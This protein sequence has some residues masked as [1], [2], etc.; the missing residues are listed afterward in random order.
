MDF[1]PLASL[2]AGQHGCFASRQL[3]DV[4]LTKHQLGRLHERGLVLGTG[5]KGV[6][7]FASAPVTWRQRVMATT[8]SMPGSLASHRTAG[9]LWE[10]DG[11]PPGRIE[12]VVEH[13][14]W[15]RR[16]VTV[17]QSK[18]LVAG[19]RDVRD[20]I[21]CTSLVRTLVDLP[22]VA[23]EARC[24]Q[25]LDHARR[26]E[27]AVLE[28]V[29]ARHLEVARRGRNGTVALRALLERR[30][31]GD[32]LPDSG[33]EAK[34][35]HLVMEAGLPDPVLQFQVRDGEFVAY[36]DL[37]WPGRMVG[38]EC[39]SLAYHYGERAHQGD[40]TRRRRLTLLGWAMLE[41]TYQDVDRRPHTVVREL[42]SALD[43]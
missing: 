29:R 40:R 33:F 39:D 25:A 31:L 30:G 24:G 34:A 21:P 28:W 5:H 20:G 11:F 41:F 15:R 17:H 16:D 4:G 6:H 32:R 27:R 23:W 18:D 9:A 37:A 43:R 38:M 1:A 22:A 7:R 3:P 42:R 2:A 26:Q 19:D 13:G 12:T 35:L 14:T 10:L 36:I 8:L